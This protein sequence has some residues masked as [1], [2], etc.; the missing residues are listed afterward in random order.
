MDPVALD[1]ATIDL[2]H[3]SSISPHSALSDV[4]DLSTQGPHEWFSHTFRFNP[5]NGEMD[6]SGKE[7]KHWELQLKRAEE[8]GLGT[9]D[10]NLIEVEIE[11]KK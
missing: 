2:V 4:E 10:Y 9:R 5:E 7:S 1:Q 6:F 3:K 11:S 8:I